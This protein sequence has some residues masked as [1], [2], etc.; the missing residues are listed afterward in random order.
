[1]AQVKLQESSAAML[2]V[3]KLV[4]MLLN[5]LLMTLTGAKGKKTWQNMEKKER[6]MAHYNV[7]FKHH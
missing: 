2:C 7:S 3:A 1:L 6:K 5:G 4:C